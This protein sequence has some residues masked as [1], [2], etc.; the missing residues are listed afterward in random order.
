MGLYVKV[1]GQRSRS[2]AKNRVLT[3]LL[4]CLKVKVKG[5][6]QGQRSGSRSRVNVKGQGQISGVQRSILGGHILIIARMRSIGVLIFFYVRPAF[7]F[8]H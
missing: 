5:Q 4:P 7:F 2:N 1:I 3:S 8:L 6:S